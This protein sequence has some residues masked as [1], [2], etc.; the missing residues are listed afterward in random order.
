MTDRLVLCA[1][2]TL[3]CLAGCGA[4]SDAAPDRAT[5]TYW[6]DVAPIVNAKCVQCHQSGGI[7]PFPLDSYAALKQRAPLAAAAVKGG[8]MPPFL[9]THDGSCGEFDGRDALT[10][11]ERDTLLAW[12]GGAMT[13][14][15]AAPVPKAPRRGL[16]GT[17]DYATPVFA[18]VAQGGSYAEHDEYRCFLVDPALEK[19]TFVAAY[20]I[21]PGTPAIVHHVAVS[22]VDPARMGTAGKTN[23]EL[24]QSLDEADP[25]RAGWPCVEF[26]GPGVSID[27]LPVMWAP[28][29]QPVVL[30]AGVGIRLRRTDR[31]VVQMH[32]NL[33]DASVRGKTDTT[34]IQLRTVDSVERRA[35]SII[36]DGFVDTLRSPQPAMLPPGQK[37]TPYSWN[38]SLGKMGLAG[39]SHADL[40]GVMPHMHERGVRSELRIAPGPGAQ[41]ACV[42]RVERWNF[43][44]QRL[45]FYAGTP[46]RVTAASE[47]ELDCEYDTSK[48]QR[49]VIPGWGTRNEMCS[50]IMLVAL[51]PGL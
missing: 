2:T 32:Y 39:D 4:G 42:A 47:L 31:L 25:D 17:R 9:V 43:H 40:I 1:I 29:Q 16:E 11:A 35:M 20:D 13:E 12:T 6:K 44:W 24:M 22:V 7:A 37:A 46:L 50:A 28:G 45:Y 41:K 48:E 49:P 36:G 21:L 26:A 10:P 3:A 14:G 27:A 33:A 18:P 23:G 15:A 8:S 5:L 51:P 38:R 30:P 34:V 19:D